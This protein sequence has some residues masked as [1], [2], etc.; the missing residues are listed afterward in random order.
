MLS[1]K[2]NSSETG[3]NEAFNI[4]KQ[5]HGLL[6]SK[7]QYVHPCFLESKSRARIESQ[8]RWPDPFPCLCWSIDAARAL[9]RCAI[10]NAVFSGPGRAQTIR[11]STALISGSEIGDGEKALVLIKKSRNEQQGK[12]LHQGGSSL[13]RS[14][15]LPGRECLSFVR[16]AG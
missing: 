5:I 12:F 11:G 16:S 15:P 4:L 1:L 13:A 8:T 10:K 3:V 6:I 7:I 2:P 14:P 9:M